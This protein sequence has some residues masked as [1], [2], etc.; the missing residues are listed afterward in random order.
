MHNF[1]Y[2]SWSG[3]NNHN[4]LAL[5]Y[6]CAIAAKPRWCEV[7]IRRLTPRLPSRLITFLYHAWYYN[8]AVSGPSLALETIIDPN[9]LAFSENCR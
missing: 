6:Y 5:V 8:S 1:Q 9:K 2:R 7:L 3:L 4:T